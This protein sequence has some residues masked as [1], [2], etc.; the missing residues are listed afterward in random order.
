M[1]DPLVSVVIPA[2]NNASMAAEA[3]ESVLAQT[4]PRIEI[5]VVDDGSNDDTHERLARFRPRITLL[6]QAHQGPAVARNAGIRASRGEFVGFLDSDDLW[7]PEKVERCL[8][9]LLADPDVGV[10]FTPARIHETDTGRRYDL[11]QY[12]RD[13]WMARDLFVECR[14]VNTSTLLTRRKHL[15]AVEGFDE[16]FFRAQ[17]WDLMVRMAEV[18]RFARVAET[19]TERRLHPR[20]LS[21]THRNLYAKYN[22][23]V[24]Q[25]AL[26]RRPDLYAE[27]KGEA[28]S[29]AYFRF[30][31]L[32]YGDF[33][34]SEARREFRH[35]LRHRW[36]WRVAGY[37]ARTALPVSLV[38]RLRAVKIALG[39]K[40]G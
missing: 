32:H 14:G 15:E 40:E 27:L 38:R 3:V 25:K 17:D 6:R 18:C 31:M 29:R 13:G 12:E 20:N 11:P 8:P 33:R 30:G 37:W 23:L 7:M 34:M 35:S 5:V 22:L 24:I 21:A 36:N 9:P 1:P 19:L 16:E 4:Y 10:V 39:T 26:A 28:M 2:W